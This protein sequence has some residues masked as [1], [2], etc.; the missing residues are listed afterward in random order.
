VTLR[1]LAATGVLFAV[2]GR[3]APVEANGAF[4]A[5]GQIAVDPSDAAH[6]VLRTNFGFLVT[7]DGGASWDWVCEPAVGY[8]NYD[9]AI[10]VTADGSVLAGLPDRLSVGTKDG[11][12]WR[13]ATEP[14]TLFTPDVTVQKDDPARAVVVTFDDATQAAQLWESA[15]AGTTWSA[16]GTP[17]PAG[18]VPATVDVAPSE[19]DRVYVS[20]IAAGA[21][22]VARSADRGGTWTVAPVPGS[23]VTTAPYLGGVHPGDP[24]RLYVRLAGPDARLYASTDGG[25]RWNV[26]HQGPG[27]LL[28][29]A[30]SPDGST[31]LVSDGDGVWRASSIDLA[32]EQVSALPVQC[33][34]WAE[35][36]VYACG[37]EAPNEYFVGLSTDAGASFVGLLHTPCIR[38]PLDCAADTA[39]GMLCPSLWPMYQAFTRYEPCDEHGHGGGGP[40]ASSSATGGAGAGGGGDVPEGSGC[41]C[42]H[43]PDRSSR[44]LPWALLWLGSALGRRAR[45]RPLP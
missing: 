35:A 26:V 36:G 31:L 14:G 6:V 11:C 44:A 45:R 29:F 23:T 30:I 19:P 15:D 1:H 17:L 34:T 37:F 32:F 8:Q 16:L 25:D 13:Q 40:A 2:L 42:S 3:A 5:G 18:L 33:L 21:G 7:H 39:A 38:G 12:S 22:V 27:F 4:P 24:D 28:G 43:L 10:A 41:S 20:G 9:P